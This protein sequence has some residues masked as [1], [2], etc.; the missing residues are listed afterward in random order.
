MIVQNFSLNLASIKPLLLNLEPN[1]LVSFIYKSDEPNYR[2]LLARITR[3]DKT[4]VI[5][6]SRAL[7]C[8]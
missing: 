1:K 5:I 4:T 6:F 2:C 7:V 8:R 3:D